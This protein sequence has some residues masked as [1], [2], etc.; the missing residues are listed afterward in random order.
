MKTFPLSPVTPLLLALAALAGCANLHPVGLP[1]AAA[2]FQAP[3]DWSQGK[4]G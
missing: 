1:P 4:A 2:P 3:A